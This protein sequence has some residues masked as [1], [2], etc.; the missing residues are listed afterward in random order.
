MSV[1][2]KTRRL[3]RL[4]GFAIA[5]GSALAWA[6]LA[7]AR[8]PDGRLELTV[9]DAAP[10]V[11]IAARIELTD[12]RHRPIRPD[13][14]PE[15]LGAAALGDH[16]YL[17]KVSVLGL[18]R[19]AYRFTLDAGPEYRTQHGHFEIARHA[20]DSKV[21]DVTRAANLAKEGW[22]AGDLGSCR[23]HD[24]Y[25]LIRRAESLAYTPKA[26]AAWREGAWQPP[27]LAERRKRDK[28]PLG[29]TALW[30]DPRGVVWLI[31]PDA[32]R[33]LESLPKPGVSTVEFLNAARVGGWRVVASITSRELPLWIAHEVVDAVVVLDAWIESPAGRA[34]AKNARPADPLRYPDKQ[35]PGRWRRALYESLLET[36]VRLPAVAVSGSGLNKRPLGT[37]RVYAHIGDDRSDTA[38]WD[39]VD[40]LATVVTNGPLLRPFVEGAAPGATFSLGPDGK[41]R[42]AIAL[43]LATRTPIEY[44]EIVKN[45]KVFQTVRLAEVAASGGRLPE[46][47][48]DAPGWLAVTVVAEN[49]DRYE[50]AMSAPWFV[51]GPDGGRRDAIAVQAWQAALADAQADFGTTDSDAYQQAETFWS[52]GG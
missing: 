40:D 1:L 33:S 34:A 41:R 24:D 17:D 28:Q 16:A 18:K 19:G 25:E 29:A 7:E 20:E 49:T 2:G 37:A 23:P 51:E 36:G 21:V 38:W 42:L 15:P 50:V 44:L 6:P 46:V 45:G 27:P 30:D 48:F 43:N 4:T 32:S 9:R 47:T 52:A 11:P 14:T 12:A 10:G 8:R 26:V 39:A 3:C 5:A 31:D 22:L 13:R 35:G